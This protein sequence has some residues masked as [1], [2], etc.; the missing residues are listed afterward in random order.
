MPCG[1]RNVYEINL[2]KM[3]WLLIYKLFSINFKG[4]FIL[5]LNFNSDFKNLLIK[6]NVF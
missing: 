4:F 5:L 1:L 6:D 3:R 2:I